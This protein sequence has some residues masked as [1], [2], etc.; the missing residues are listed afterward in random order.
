MFR[1]WWPKGFVLLSRGFVSALVVGA[2]LFADVASRAGSAHQ[3][4]SARPSAAPWRHPLR[5]A[6]V[7]PL[8]GL[9][10]GPPA[11]NRY[12]QHQ[13][14]Y[15]PWYGYGFAVPTFNWGY[16]GAH[17]HGTLLTG[18]RGYHEDFWQFS[19]QRGY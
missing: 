11:P 2:L 7:R 6:G 12:A 15:Y 18:F 5:P 9:S 10:W 19:Y 14:G 16:F 4:D 8:V 17:G 1:T 13:A 3:P